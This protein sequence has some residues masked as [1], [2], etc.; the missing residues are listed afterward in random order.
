MSA[1]GFKRVVAI[2]TSIMLLLLQATPA[3][4]LVNTNAFSDGNDSHPVLTKSV[5]D[6]ENDTVDEQKKLSGAKTLADTIGFQM[7]NAA[8][9]AVSVPMPTVTATEPTTDGEVKLSGSV[10][11]G[12][13]VYYSFDGKTFMLADSTTSDETWS[14][15]V[16]L[17]RSGNNT[18]YVYS[19]KSNYQSGTA[20]INV[21]FTVPKP[22]VSATEPTTDGE[23]KLSGFVTAGYWVYYSFDGKTFM[24]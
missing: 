14:K 7:N 15:V 22:T 9:S 21:A 18:I 8:A 19:K 6:Q 5:N 13:W 3:E 24:L 1:L 12:Y 20:T 4:G 16:T 2:T 10:T 17:P 11:A 23:V